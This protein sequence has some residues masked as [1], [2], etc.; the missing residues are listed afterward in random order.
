[1]TKCVHFIVIGNEDISQHLA[2]IPQFK[3]DEVV[4]FVTEDSQ[5]SGRIIED[6]KE[7]GVSYRSIKVQEQF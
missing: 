7:M 5:I 6:L 2:G 3:A 1:M 4:L